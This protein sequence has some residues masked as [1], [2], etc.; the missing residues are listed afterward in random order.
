MR[1]R[2][3]CG[4]EIRCRMQESRMGVSGQGGHMTLSHDPDTDN[5]TAIQQIKKNN[6][7]FEDG[8]HPGSRIVS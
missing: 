1:Y 2:Y 8:T 4:R 6:M 7:L 3:V 5:D